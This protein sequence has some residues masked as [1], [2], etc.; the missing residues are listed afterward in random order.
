LSGHANAFARACLE[1]PGPIHSGGIDLSSSP[2]RNN[3]QLANGPSVN[4]AASTDPP[5]YSTLEHSR[6][7]GQDAPP[8]GPMNYACYAM[9]G[10]T[11][12]LL[13]LL[14]NLPSLLVI[15]PMSFVKHRNHQNPSLALK[16]TAI[17]SR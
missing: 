8:P 15:W 7:S 6:D 4:T 11:E 1:P 2:F 12:K 16:K 10:Q 9:L 5:K 17:Y 3:R 13:E 14:N